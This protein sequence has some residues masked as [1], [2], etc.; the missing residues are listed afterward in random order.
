[1]KKYE[2]TK[3]TKTLADDTVLHLIR[4][5]MDIPRYCVKAGELGGFVE[6]EDNLSQDG[7]AIALPKF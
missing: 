4:A 7:N 5:L 1:M 2:L 3:E 6:S